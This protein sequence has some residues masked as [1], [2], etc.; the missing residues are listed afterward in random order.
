MSLPLAIENRG[1]EIW[2]VALFAGEPISQS[3]VPQPRWRL[4]GPG[5]LG[6]SPPT[7]PMPLPRDVAPG[8]TIS[9][10]ARLTTPLRPGDYALELSLTQ[11]RGE[12]FPE[13]RS[14][15]LTTL[16]DV[17]PADGPEGAATPTEAKGAGPEAQSG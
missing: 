10:T 6:A 17:R 1:R 14:P 3:V 5:R 8:E 11:H 4:L 12:P 15:P 13:D 16:V 7:P 2:P 9:I